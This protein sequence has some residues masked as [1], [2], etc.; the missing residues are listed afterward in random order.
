MCS[1]FLCET[2]LTLLN[3]LRR[4]WSLVVFPSPLRRLDGFNKS[5]F[6]DF[7]LCIAQLIPVQHMVHLPPPFR[8]PRQSWSSLLETS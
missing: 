5:T 2:P 3:S 7:K 4:V 1:S 6:G 8:H